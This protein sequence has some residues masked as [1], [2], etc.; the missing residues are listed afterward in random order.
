MLDL[1]QRFNELARVVSGTARTLSFL[2]P[3]SA[4]AWAAMARSGHAPAT[5]LT[6]NGQSYAD[7]VGLSD[8]LQGG[9]PIRKP[10]P[11]NPYSP[12]VELLSHAAVDPCNT[13]INDLI[14][15][16]LTNFPHLARQASMITG[17][18]HDN[19]PS[20]ASGIGFSMAQYYPSRN[21]LEICVA[22]MGRGMLS[23]VKTIDSSITDH[24]EAVRWCVQEGHTTAR[25]ADE[26]A[27]HLP[28]D[29]MQNPY[30][31]SIETRHNENSHA[32][33]G[34]WKLAEII[35]ATGG[36]L[37][38]W[39]GDAR[40][41]IHA[42]HEDLVRVPFWQGVIAGLRLPVAQNSGDEGELALQALEELAQ[43]LEL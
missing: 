7:T 36:S 27:Q 35:R 8:I 28:E 13:V 6:G 21:E 23:N 40:W 20:H 37:C 1:I 4:T 24:R 17:E 42:G 38:I 41:Q 9:S 31:A 33:L 18:L 29:A 30:N 25:N 19:V 26:W 15:S 11:G 2:S 14:H 22:D 43:R 39:S 12:L 16:Q 10:T 32:G 3:V 5:Q 34:L